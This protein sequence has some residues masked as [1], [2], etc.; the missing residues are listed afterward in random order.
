MDTFVQ[1]LMQDYGVV[2]IAF[3][4]FLENIFPPIPSEIIMPLAGYQAATGD[5]S[6]FSVVI[7]G[8][9]G[10]ILGILPWYYLGLWFGEERIIRL[11]D[12]YGRWMTMTAEDVEAADRWFRKYGLWAVLFGRLVPTVRTLISVPAGLSRMPMP[13]FL[14]FSAIGTLVWTTGLALA[15]YLLAQQYELVDQYVG[16]VSNGVIAIVVLIYIYRVVTFKPSK[17]SRPIDLQAGD[18]NRAA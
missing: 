5:H 10:S 7:A 8:T 2:G 3:L 13:T 6:F 18:D 1:S 15:G 14:F 11:A 16:P 9:L 12:R 17:R 4:M